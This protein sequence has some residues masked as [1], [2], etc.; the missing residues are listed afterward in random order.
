MKQPDK[1]ARKVLN[2]INNNAPTEI[3]IPNTKVKLKL[4]YLRE[5]TIERLTDVWSEVDTTRTAKDAPETLKY[6]VKFPLKPY[7]EAAL[8]YLNSYWKIR[9][10]YHF[11]VWWWSQVKGYSIDQMNAVIVEGKKKLTEIL[12]SYYA[13]M[14]LTLDTR[15]DLM[16]MTSKEAEQYRAELTSVAEQL[17]S[18]NTPNLGVQEDSSSVL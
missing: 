15:E 9:L 1:Y 12:R 10:F 14:V 8:Y 11:L 18:K 3:T 16:K 7:K 4:R 6:A 17:S 2:D 5:Y 13:N